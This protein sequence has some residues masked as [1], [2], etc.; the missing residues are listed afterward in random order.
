MNERPVTV[1]ATK[2]QKLKND[3]TCGGHG[4]VADEPASQGGTDEG[5]MPFEL[6]A[7]ALG[8][9]TSMTMRLYADRKGYPLEAAEVVLTQTVEGTERTI[10]RVIT[11]TGALD[12]EARQKILEIANKC[13][14]H[15][16]LEGSKV[17]VVTRLADG[18]P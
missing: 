13:P 2:A 15:R 10:E 4:L 1:R 5:L 16:A 8:A 3:I 7:S 12:D 11:L 14:V 9:C 18:A 6:L 17:K